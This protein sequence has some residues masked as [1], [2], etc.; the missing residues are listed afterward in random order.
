MKELTLALLL[1]ISSNTSL[2]YDGLQVP[3]VMQV[4]EEKLADILYHG[5]VPKGR[6][7]NRVSVA[8]VYNFRD[9]AIYLLDS[10]DLETVEGRAVLV[11]ELVHYLQYRNGLD[12]SVE[13]IRKLE[14][15]AYA[16]QT[17]FLA[18]HG[19]G[20]EFDDMH[21]LLASNCWRG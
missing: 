19:K 6:N 8:G 10:E 2:T 3:E 13:C 16:A 20:P 1:W 5:Q 12:K 18:Q 4:P 17:K 9:G 14:P 11:H 15:A 7:V 21:I